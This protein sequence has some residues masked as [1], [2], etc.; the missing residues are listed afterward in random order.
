MGNVDMVPQEDGIIDFVSQFLL[1]IKKQYPVANSK[2]FE[3]IED[4]IFEFVMHG[5]IF[6]NRNHRI[7]RKI[8]PKVMLVTGLGNP[9]NRL[10]ASV[11]RSLGGEVIGFGH[12]N[13]FYY[14]CPEIFTEDC[15]LFADHY[16]AHSNG[17]AK[18]LNDLAEK[19]S[20]EIKLP[21]I[22]HDTENCY[23]PLFQKLQRRSVVVNKIK[24]I[25]LVG[26]PMDDYLYPNI[27]IHHC[28]EYLH[29]EL[30]LVRIMKSAGY[31]VIYKAHPD[32]LE[33]IEG[34][35][36]NYVDMVITERFEDVFDQA[37]CLVFSYGGTSFGFA[38]LTKKPIVCMNIN[39]RLINPRVLESMKKRC[40]MIEPQLDYSGRLIF[41]ENEVINAV[42]TSLVNINYDI[43]HEFA[44]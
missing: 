22:T 12:G 31:Y 24:K 26:M 43:L 7:L 9:V 41:K 40:S 33:E 25:M 2:R 37:D 42:E 39:D 16:V 34:V 6:F 30:Q 14:G 3:K 13:A 10:F 15:L 29:L 4:A 20:L 44:F 8:K 11:W 23:F 17:Q 32:R 38:L 28:L 5:L 1:L 35:F 19:I 36:D 21:K 27:P 18:I